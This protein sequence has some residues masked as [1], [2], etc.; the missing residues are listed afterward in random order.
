MAQRDP[1]RLVLIRAA[2]AHGLSQSDIAMLAGV[3]AC[4]V[5]RYMSGS[6]PIPLRLAVAL[7]KAG[8]PELL[9]AACREAGGRYVESDTQDECSSG[10]AQDLSAVMRGAGRYAEVLAR[11]LDD[12]VVLPAEHREIAE[13]LAALRRVVERLEHTHWSGASGSS[14]RSVG[15]GDAA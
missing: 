14:L 10:P 12:G 4:S 7:S 5:S 2:D 1:L 9:D 15:G 3:E 13:A 8:C 6:Y 11:A